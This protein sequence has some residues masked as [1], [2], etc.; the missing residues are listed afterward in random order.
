M[1]DSY[2]LWKGES[3]D[4]ALRALFSLTDSKVAVSSGA[5]DDL[6]MHIC[7]KSTILSK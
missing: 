6:P 3:R 1:D 7:I 2:E 5:A 4:A